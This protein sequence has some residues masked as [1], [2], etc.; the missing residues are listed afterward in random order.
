MAISDD[1]RNHQTRGALLLMWY[2]LCRPAEATGALW[3][4]IDWDSGLWRIP[5]E[6][7]KMREAHASPLPRQALGLMRRMQVINGTRLHVF[8]HRDILD[9]SMTEAAL[10]QALYHR[11]ARLTVPSKPRQRCRS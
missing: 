2:T 5:V 6:R 7:M 11:C 9:R 10:R 4:E 1:Q 8:P 3:S